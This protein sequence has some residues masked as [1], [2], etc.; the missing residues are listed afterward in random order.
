M[1]E[2]AYFII[3]MRLTSYEYQILVQES[4]N[5]DLGFPEYVL[6]WI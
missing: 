3:L 1:I 5:P 2:L 4:L 6:K